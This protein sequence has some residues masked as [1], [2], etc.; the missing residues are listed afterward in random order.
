MRPLPVNAVVHWLKVRRHDG[1]KPIEG[2]KFVDERSLHPV[3]RGDS[4]LFRGKAR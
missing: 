4:R 2:A 1:A 3:S